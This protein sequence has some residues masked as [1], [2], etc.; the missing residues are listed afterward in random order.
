MGCQTLVQ[1]LHNWYERSADSDIIVLNV[2][3][4]DRWQNTATTSTAANWHN[5][6]GLTWH[7]VADVDGWWLRQWGADNGTQHAYWVLDQDGIITW[8]KIDGASGD[9]LDI[10]NAV[11]AIP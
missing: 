9:V 8:R 10:V 7:T 5:T 4:K 3:T 1:G 11:E 2:I 6:F